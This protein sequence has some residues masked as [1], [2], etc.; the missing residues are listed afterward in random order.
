MNLL[1]QEAQGG[2]GLAEIFHWKSMEAKVRKKTA[3]MCQLLQ[4]TSKV[5]KG[6]CYIAWPQIKC[7]NGNHSDFNFRVF[8]KYILTGPAIYMHG[9]NLIRGL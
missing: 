6:R 7:R 8:C 1:R 3:W 2:G 9:D 4:W 5:G